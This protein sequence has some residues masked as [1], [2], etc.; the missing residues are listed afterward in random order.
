MHPAN[1][2]GRITPMHPFFSSD[3]VSLIQTLWDRGL[4][5]DDIMERL[6]LHDDFRP[7][8]QLVIDQWVQ[9][10]DDTENPSEPGD[11]DYYPA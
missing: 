4:A 10:C 7:E 5:V 6:D 9:A 2:F 3:T 8:V 1:L 11:L